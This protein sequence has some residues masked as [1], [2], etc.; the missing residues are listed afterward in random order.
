MAGYK[1]EFR[2]SAKV[3]ST[4]QFLYNLVA[5][6]GQSPYADRINL[7]FGFEFPLKKKE[8]AQSP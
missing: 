7:M 8:P 4:V 2:Y 3:I 5:P 6:N 1:R